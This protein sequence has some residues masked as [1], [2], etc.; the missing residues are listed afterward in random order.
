MKNDIKVT[1]CQIG[2]ESRQI[3]ICEEYYIKLLHYFQLGNPKF[4]E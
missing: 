3:M 2:V 1:E 4:V